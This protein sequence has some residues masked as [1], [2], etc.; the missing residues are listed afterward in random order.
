MSNPTQIKP[1]D[2]EP[3][4]GCIDF[5]TDLLERARRGDIRHVAAVVQNH[6]RTVQTGWSRA[7]G[8]FHMS[9][10]GG[11]AHL[12]AKYERDVVDGTD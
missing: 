3:V 1:V 5:C 8:V 4:Q 6:D 2:K 9:M 10:L 7:A 12:T 11:L